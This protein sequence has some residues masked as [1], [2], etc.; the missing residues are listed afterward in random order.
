MIPIN[1]QKVDELSKQPNS[2]KTNGKDDPLLYPIF[3]HSQTN[4]HDALQ[5]FSTYE[6]A[7]WTSYIDRWLSNRS[8]KANTRGYKRGFIVLVDLGASN[9]GHE[10]SFTH[11]AVVLAQT[12]DSLLIAPCSSKKYG[13]GYPEIIDASTSDG[14]SSNTGIQTNA[15]RW[16][17]KNRV[18]A[19]LGI[20]TSQILNKIDALL[21]KLIPL[22]TK[23]IL[24]KDKIITELENE[25]SSL[26]E[27]LQI[28][29][30]KLTSL[31]TTDS[32]SY[33]NTID[34]PF[35]S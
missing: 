1:R 13:K 24:E 8:A 12:K 31:Q 34:K 21:L 17:S 16:I 26:K 6:M 15:I 19:Q 2:K 7:H 35:P 3:S 30:S 18:I 23:Y 22:H 5:D 10:P 20:T 33:L 28:L 29:N 25:N 27:E 14:F 4:V 32:H 11:P 9:F